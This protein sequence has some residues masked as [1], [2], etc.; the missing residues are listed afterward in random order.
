MQAEQEQEE[1]QTAV[2]KPKPLL[3]KHDF[4]LESLEVQGLF[5]AICYVPLHNIQ[6][7]HHLGMMS[8]FFSRCLKQIQE[9]VF[10]GKFPTCGELK[11]P[12]RLPRIGFQQVPT[13]R[14]E[15]SECCYSRRVTVVHNHKH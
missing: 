10:A 6:I 15:M 13:R 5:T 1:Q 9:I 12:S 4:G 2:G 14:D 8:A 11:D 7:N 3:S